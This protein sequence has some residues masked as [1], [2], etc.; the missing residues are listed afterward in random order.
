MYSEVQIKKEKN[1]CELEK[2]GICRK[3]EG[4]KGLNSI[5]VLAPRS[6]L[7]AVFTASLAFALTGR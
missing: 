3:T 2:K 5:G 1:T 6:L 4:A 7:K